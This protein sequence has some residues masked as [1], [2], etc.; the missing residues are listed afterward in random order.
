MHL[1]DCGS[2]LL[3]HTVLELGG[4]VVVQSGVQSLFR[5]FG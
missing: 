3:E 1:L 5:D 2:I 4:R